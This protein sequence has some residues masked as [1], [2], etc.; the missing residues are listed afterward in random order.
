MRMSKQRNPLF[1][2]EN[3]NASMVHITGGMQ[4]YDPRVPYQSSFDFFLDNSTGHNTA[5]TTGIMPTKDCVFDDC[6]KKVSTKAA[7]LGHARALHKSDFSNTADLKKKFNVYKC[8]LCSNLFSSLRDHLHCIDA[9]HRTGTRLPSVVN[10]YQQ[11][12]PIRERTE[13][14]NKQKKWL[15]KWSK[16]KKNKKKMDE[17]EE[18][19]PGYEQVELTWED[20]R[21]LVN[22]G[23]VKKHGSWYLSGH[24]WEPAVL[25]MEVADIKRYVCV[26]LSACVCRDMYVCVCVCVCM[27]VYVHVFLYI[28]IGF[29]NGFTLGSAWCGVVTCRVLSWSRRRMLTIGGMETVMGFMFLLF[30]ELQRSLSHVVV[31]LPST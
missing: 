7:F 16:M 12:K 25:G 8:P 17:E 9:R 27:C 2:S 11:I 18:Q 26:C 28:Y 24:D 22:N 19:H 21:V 4:E 23:S 6:T 14:L 3:K 30:R 13:V 20:F 15:Q 10:T 1:H 5:Y 31:A 29:V